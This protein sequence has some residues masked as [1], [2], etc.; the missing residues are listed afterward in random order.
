M[1]RVA[2]TFLMY[3]GRKH[4]GWKV[5]PHAATEIVQSQRHDF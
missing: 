3:A 2:V 4:R 5:R 1:Q